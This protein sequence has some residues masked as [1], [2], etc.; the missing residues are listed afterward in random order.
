[1]TQQLTHQD[2]KNIAAL[3]AVFAC[4][5]LGLFMLL[6]VF[7]PYAQNLVGS[8]PQT[9]G[10]AFGI[11]GLSQA[12]LQLPFGSLSDRFGRK[13]IILIGLVCFAA[14]SI[15]CALS[16]SIHSM[17][18]G[19][20]LQGAG[21]IGSTVM[22]LTADLTRDEIR[23]RAMAIIGLSIGAAFALSLILG[24]LLAGMIGVSG[25]F[26]FI[27]SL[28]ILSMVLIIT[29]VPTPKLSASPIAKQ[30][31]KQTLATVLC[32]RQLL[33]LDISIGLQHL[34]LTAS[35]VVL[36]LCLINLAEIPSAHHWWLYLPVLCLSV[37]L[38]VPCVILAEKYQHMK[39]MLLV[40]ITA[41]LI[42]QALLWLH[43]SHAWWISLMLVLFFAGFN[44]LEACLPSMISKA[45]PIPSK[46]TALGIYSSVQFLGIFIGGSSAGWLYQH[47]GL[48]SVFLFCASLAVVWLLLIACLLQAPRP[49]ATRCYALKAADTNHDREQSIRQLPGVVEAYIDKQ[50]QYL[51]LKIDKTYFS[52]QSL[53]DFVEPSIQ[54]Q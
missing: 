49:W 17:M 32:Q 6:P 3:A 26:W 29:V 40:S 43:H 50:G 4:R 38:M 16:H 24:P 7:T 41:I 54:H 2:Y 34:I 48:A 14:G 46:G 30:N 27:L 10:I 31:F 20:A 42:A 35:F 44:V 47:L 28:A 12:C 53:A 8:T 18:L 15:V 52:T 1:M 25:L 36:P 22:A 23:T 9:I 51:H 11:Y 37:A 5:L 33:L 39:A 19:R 45:A 21:A 13:P